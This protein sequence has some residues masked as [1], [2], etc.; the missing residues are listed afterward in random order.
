MSLLAFWKMIGGGMVG[1]VWEDCTDAI[2][3]CCRTVHTNVLKK[4][5]EWLKVIKAK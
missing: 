3:F 4:V 1:R 5:K 2:I